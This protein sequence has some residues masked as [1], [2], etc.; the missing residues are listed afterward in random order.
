MPRS[1]GKRNFVLRDEGDE[2]AVFSGDTPRQAALKAARRID[3]DSN[4]LGPGAD[5]SKIRLHGEEGDVIQLREKGTNKVHVYYAW[6]W[7]EDTTE[8]EPD[9]LGETVVKANVAK[10]MVKH[11]K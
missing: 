2:V 1:D 3:P 6:S 11:I 4:E 9:W 7:E 8:D 10:S 5:P